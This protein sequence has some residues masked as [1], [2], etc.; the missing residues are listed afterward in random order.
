MT[1]QMCLYETISGFMPV[2]RVLKT[3]LRFHP[4]WCGSV[5]WHC[6]ENRKVTY[7]I[8]SQGTCL[9]CGPGRGLGV[10]KRQLIEVSL[11]H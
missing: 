9:D 10:C 1:V 6:P 7:L 11:A 3:Y 2:F 8:P 5:D 4:G